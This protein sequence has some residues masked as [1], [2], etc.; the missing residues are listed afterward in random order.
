MAYLRISSVSGV[1]NADAQ[2]L[3]AFLSSCTDDIR[4]A[5][6]AVEDFLKEQPPEAAL[7]FFRLCF[8]LLLQ[9]VFGF[10][11]SASSS[12][13]AWLVRATDEQSASALRSLLH[14]SGH[15]FV[16]LLAL[17]REKAVQFV[18]PNERLP[19]R[20]RQLLLLDRGVTLLSHTSE[21]FKNRTK[22]SNVGGLQLQLDLFEYY[23]F[24]FAYYAASCEDYG[25]AQSASGT[26]HNRRSF[27]HWVS[28]V[29]PTSTHHSTKPNTLRYA[30]Y[31]QLLHL[32][33]THFVQLH[34]FSGMVH[35]P[36]TTSLS[37]GGFLFL[38][39]LEFWLMKDDSWP[40][41]TSQLGVTTT[42]F[43]HS[44]LE[45]DAVRLIVNHSNNLLK[46]SLD[47]QHGTCEAGSLVA[48]GRGSGFPLFVGS[49]A[50]CSLT[51]GSG[52]NLPN[53]QLLQRPLYRFISRA[54]EYW[55][56]GI[57]V[58]QAWY[59]VDLWVDYMQPWFSDVDEKSAA[60]VDD[61]HKH[62]RRGFSAMWKGYVTKN[63][64]FYTTLVVHFLYFALK[65]VSSNLEPVLE[66]TAKVLGT[67]AESK[68]L[69]GLLRKVESAV[70]AKMD[71][72]HVLSTDIDWEERAPSNES[73]LSY[74]LS[75][76]PSQEMQ[77]SCLFALGEGG[78][79]HTFQMLVLQ[80]EAEI[81]FVAPESQRNRLNARAA[82]RR[83]GSRSSHL[84]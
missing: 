28:G 67:L 13:S 57:S 52:T 24:W 11:D 25:S 19:L 10:H 40:L 31:L 47:T 59:L 27:S 30:L 81:Q 16:S 8:P 1:P 35:I 39:T 53:F 5:C 32:Y 79:F 64:P 3:H 68:D 29:H 72:E 4:G 51:R 83:K 42:G 9:K 18:F 37:Q 50:F 15:L 46:A 49:R 80:C 34:H 14:P 55:P 7:G 73:N 48:A 6:G 60:M 63:D 56:A 21:L 54:F 62:G 44:G 66:M 41:Q 75:P 74:S 45:L 71:I 78:A 26:K 82:R 2:N 38:T 23:M 36:G 17:D 61:T 84:F 12:S 43:T 70:V 20:V 65:Y 69:L 76:A 22:V 58:K 77:R 33:L